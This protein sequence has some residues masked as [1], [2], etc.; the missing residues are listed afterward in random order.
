[1]S[2]SRE[3][4]FGEL[5]SVLSRGESKEAWDELCQVIDRFSDVE[6]DQ[7]I[8]PYVEGSVRSWQAE[9]CQAP[10]EWVKRALDG[11]D[12]PFWAIVRALDISCEYLNAKQ[13]EQLMQS[14]RM[15]GV[16][17]LD[18]SSNRVRSTGA[19]YLAHANHLSSLRVLKAGF[20]E[21]GA[22]GMQV[23]T[24]S[25]G[26]FENLSELYVDG[27]L[28]DSRGLMHL[29]EAPWFASL[30]V[31]DV[32]KNKLEN[33]ALHALFDGLSRHGKIRRLVC[34]GN[35]FTGDG[36]AMD[37]LSQDFD[38]LE[39]LEVRSCELNES[40]L[41]KFMNGNWS[42]LKS[43]D[44]SR[45]RKLTD[46]HV[47]VMA[48]NSSFQ[49][50]ERLSLGGTDITLDALDYLHQLTS[51]THVTIPYRSGFRLEPLRIHPFFVVCSS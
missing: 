12:L 41:F 16:E 38:G 37:A 46:D 15:Q 14:E 30:E 40:D 36:C 26:V 28:I 13:F 48:N 34:D 4:F 19:L 45:N 6:L 35:T 47:Q 2:G 17:V 27:N 18:M 23:L 39:I 20:N 51:L 49:Q 3:R 5:R 43:L 11:E 8:F 42:G 9:V 44:L 21:L 25:Q 33:N 50:L 22:S 31:L 24:Q 29:L 32:A 10:R 7:M 1:M